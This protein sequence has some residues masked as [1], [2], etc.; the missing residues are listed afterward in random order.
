MPGGY[1]NNRGRE[2]GGHGRDH[3]RSSGSTLDT[4]RIR[5]KT[6]ELD[7]ELFNSVAKKCADQVSDCPR[8]M[9]KATQLRKFYDELCLWD[10]KVGLDEDRFRVNLP[11]IRMM[12]AKVAYAKGRKLV[13]QNY[14]ALL[15]HCLNNIGSA[16]EFRNCKLFMEAFMGFYKSVRPQ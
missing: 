13:D 7:P 15:S 11:F 4:S 5:F 6:E 1:R 16:R 9:N 3:H 8:H 14:L 10:S 12:N 2:G